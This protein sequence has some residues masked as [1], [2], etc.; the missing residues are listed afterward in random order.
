LVERSFFHI[1]H[2][3]AASEVR[4]WTAGC[5]DWDCF[6]SEPERWP[7]SQNQ[8]RSAVEMVAHSRDALH[9]RDH[10]FFQE[11]MP[12]EVWRCWSAF[13]DKVVY[14]DIE[15]DGG[16]GPDAVTI[17]GLYDGFEFRCLVKGK[18]LDEFPEIMADKAMIVTFFGSGFDLPML[19]KRF[20]QVPLDQIHFD[21]CPGFRRIGMRGGLKQI[22]RDVGIE[23]TDGAYGLNG[24]DAIFLW[25]R[26][27]YG[28]LGALDRLIAYNRADV[29]N[30]EALSYI[31]FERLARQ[32][33][34]AAGLGHHAKEMVARRLL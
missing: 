11:A 18:D 30:L 14:L 26:Y 22:E 27:R 13:R 32:T 10:R 24:R 29:V 16:F 12:N 23:R 1:P 6:L 33:L 21:L 7:L 17:I 3:G 2:I 8:R 5:H 31:C 28:D 25:N 15:T 20:P 19:R 4:L 9:A 34:D